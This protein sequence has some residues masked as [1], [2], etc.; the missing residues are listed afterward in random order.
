M[1]RGIV[2][3]GTGPKAQNHDPSFA[4]KMVPPE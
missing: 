1:G 3:V 4:E 2:K